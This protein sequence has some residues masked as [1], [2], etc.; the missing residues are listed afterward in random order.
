MNR[1]SAGG[2]V[3]PF[4]SSNGSTGSISSASPPGG[5]GGGMGGMRGG[6][7]SPPQVNQQM[8]DNINNNREF[9]FLARVYNTS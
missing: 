8:G 7:A 9:F 1:A 5:R 3:N 6:T 4:S 2:A